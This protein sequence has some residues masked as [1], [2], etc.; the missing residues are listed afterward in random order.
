MERAVA[1]TVAAF[2][3]I[4]AVFSN[5][6]T[7]GSGWLHETSVEDFEAV[8]RINLTGGFIVRTPQ[9][10]NGGPHSFS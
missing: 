9:L 6:G 10:S 7:S 3:G 8:I 2:G 4:D 1:Q 5:A